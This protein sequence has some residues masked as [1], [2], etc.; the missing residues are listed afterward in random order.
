MA[1]IVEIEAI[2]RVQCIYGSIILRLLTIPRYKLVCGPLGA[3]LRV[4]H[5]EHVWE[6]GAEVGSVCVMVARGFRGVDV[7]AF[8]TIEF[9][10]RLA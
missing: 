5:E 2:R 7:H 6:A 3:V 10:H 4:N 1:Q 9:D 8:R